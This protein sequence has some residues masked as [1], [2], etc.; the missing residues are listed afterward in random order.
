M[1]RTLNIALKKKNTPNKTPQQNKTTPKQTSKAEQKKPREIVT[2]NCTFPWLMDVVPSLCQ[3]L[4]QGKEI[5][6]IKG[7]DFKESKHR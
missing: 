1:Y 4:A 7:F 2:Y 5:E 3:V 6:A